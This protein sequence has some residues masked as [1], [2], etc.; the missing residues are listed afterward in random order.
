MK[1][2]KINAGDFF[3][4]DN[5]GL[6]YGLQEDVDFPEYVEWFETEEEREKVIKEN[7]MVVV[8]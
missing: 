4:D 8:E 1:Y 7:K 3:D 2:I 5:N 6:I